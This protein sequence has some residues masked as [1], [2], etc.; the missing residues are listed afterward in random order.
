MQAQLGGLTEKLS[1][2]NIYEIP[3]RLRDYAAD[4]IEKPVYLDESAV[5]REARKHFQAVANELNLY[6][7]AHGKRPLGY[8]KLK[9]KALDEPDLKDMKGG[10]MSTV[11]GLYKP[12]T[13]EL[14]LNRWLI[15]N[16]PLLKDVLRHELAHHYQDEG[17]IIE[18]YLKQY[19]EAR[20][21]PIIED[22]ADMLA[23]EM[24][25][26]KPLVDKRFVSYN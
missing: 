9:I 8:G 21:V 24:K 17:E 23:A 6:L 16:I 19:G 3:Y 12:G 20:G 2:D 7:V 25:E 5:V 26:Y 22:E 10:G 15:Y 1:D 18:G 14:C 11:L 13:D 4:M